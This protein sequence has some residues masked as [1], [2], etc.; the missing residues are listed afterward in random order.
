MLSKCECPDSMGLLKDL[1][2]LSSSA[3]CPKSWTQNF[4]ENIWKNKAK[5]FSDRINENV[6]LER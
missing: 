2:I 3:D 6:F 1:T 5:I 4:I